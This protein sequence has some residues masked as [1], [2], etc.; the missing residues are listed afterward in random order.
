MHHLY[1]VW[2]QFGLENADHQWFVR[3]TWPA[4]FVGNSE[5]DYYAESLTKRL[6]GASPSIAEA[7]QIPDPV[8]MSVFPLTNLVGNYRREPVEKRLVFNGAV[9]NSGAVRLAGR[10]VTDRA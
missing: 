5:P 6:L 7:L 9:G 4:D 3:S 1:S 2:P 10:T 8:D